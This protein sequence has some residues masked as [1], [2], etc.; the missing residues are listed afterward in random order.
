MGGKA[1]QWDKWREKF[2]KGDDSVT[3]SALSRRKA[4]PALQSLR[5]QSAKEGWVEQR[6]RYRRELENRGVNENG[7][8]KPE[9]FDVIDRTNRIIDTA[10][11]LTQH[12]TLARALVGVAAKGLKNLDPKKL[13]P[14]E[15]VSLAKLGVDIQ[16]TVEGL[17]TDKT[18]VGI[19]IDAIPDAKTEDLI[20]KRDAIRSRL[21]NA[22][23]N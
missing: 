23:R 6:K 19:S 22:D 13:K 14:T 5:V 4:S 9:V 10:E 3:L 16:R 15:I 12:N 21:A 7:E 20:L 18:E 1:V 11:M 17:A 2:V 8:I